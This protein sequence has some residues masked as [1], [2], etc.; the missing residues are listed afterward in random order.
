MGPQ[1]F[2]GCYL[3]YK[4]MHLTPLKFIQTSAFL[5]PIGTAIALLLQDAW[6]AAGV[7]LSGMFLVSNLYLWALIVRFVL[8]Q[9]TENASTSGLHMF[10]FMKLLVLSTC[11]LIGSFIFPVMSVVIGNS[12]VVLSVLLPSFYAS[13]K[14]SYSSIPVGTSL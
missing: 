12:I 2:T 4:T 3:S 10:L 7:L 9:I 5:L 6:F 14:G 8:A 1:A 11:V 13:F